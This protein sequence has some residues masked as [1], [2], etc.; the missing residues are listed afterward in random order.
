MKSNYTLYGIDYEI[1][2]I[3]FKG[4][5]IIDLK[6]VVVE[7]NV[8]EDIFNNTMAVDATLL[9]SVGLLERVPIIGD[10]KIVLRYK[11]SNE[12]DFVDLLFDVYKVSNRKI[13]EE[14]SH[15]IV[16]H[17]VSSEAVENFNSK[18]E[19]SYVNQTVSTIVSKI[20]KEFLEHVSTK[21]IEIE[22]TLGEHS[23]VF[24]S[25]P[26][27]AINLV[28]TEA[29]STKYKNKSTFL[30]YENKEGFKFKTISS[31]LDQDAVENYYFGE[32][33]LEQM[34]DDSEEI[35]QFQTIVALDF[36][37]TFD[38]LQGLD[39][40]MY[41][42]RLYI[43]D[44]VLK[45]STISDFNYKNDFSKLE[46]LSTK[47][48]ISD[49]GRIA[50]GKIPSHFRFISSQITSSDYKKESYLNGKISAS[51]DPFLAS[52]R[53]RQRFLNNAISEKA[54]FSQYTL[55]ITIP[56]NSLLKC[57]DVI[58]VFIPQN[59]D[60]EEDKQAYL[61]LFGQTDPKFLITAVRHNYKNTTGY[62][63]T[64][65]N[66]VKETFDKVIESEYQSQDEAA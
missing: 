48:I 19:R 59:S 62:Y 60:V 6:R 27:D 22:S 33:N 21:K 5:Q 8:Y 28:S 39:L 24:G 23:F 14:R 53:K 2:L 45:R 56:G 16:L 38:T 58:N 26:F 52:P 10:E 17:G 49:N 30:F 15:L 40:G 4:D 55:N 46:H 34:R 57:G 1:G 42:N 66:C 64:T 31:L 44:P 9:D 18:V 29:E 7:F 41:S 50:K 25:N 61:K 3:N 47:K 11:T 54:T 63:T 12:D 35:K 51:N 13:V 32:M 37:R 36:E 20:Y 65:L 43:L